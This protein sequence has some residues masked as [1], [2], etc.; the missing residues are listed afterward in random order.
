MTMKGK[1]ATSK[2]DYGGQLMVKMINY[3]MIG[4]EA[5]IQY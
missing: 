1:V 3:V 4:Y 5:Y 2:V